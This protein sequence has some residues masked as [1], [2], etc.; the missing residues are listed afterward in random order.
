MTYGTLTNYAA[1][2]IIPE[3]WADQIGANF[4]A[5]FIG[6][7]G[8]AGQMVYA[9]G[10]NA[11]T[12]LAPGTAYQVLAYGTANAPEWNNAGQ[13][14]KIAETELSG[15]ATTIDFSDIPQTYKHLKII[16]SVRGDQAAT[17]DTVRMRVNNNS[18]ADDH[19]HQILLGIGATAAAA[20]GVTDQTSAEVAIVSG[21]SATA[22]YFGSFELTISDYTDANKAPIWI[23]NNSLVIG[24]A[25]SN[26]YVRQYTG[27]L[28]V[29][30]AVTRLTFF[31]GGGSNLVE[32]SIIS[33]Y[34]IR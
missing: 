19:A 6:Q 4:A 17:T 9:T 27:V 20:E 33:L 28:D 13:M 7:A 30:G 23:S 10:S 12:P 31:P 18:T 8:T 5:S 2:D 21:A 3:S 14:W 29:A 25:T 1:G 26:L 22:R 15:S 34:G 32:H 24:V 16:G 11:V